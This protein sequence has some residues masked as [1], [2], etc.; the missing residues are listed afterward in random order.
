MSIRI[1]VLPGAFLIGTLPLAAQQTTNTGDSRATPPATAADAVPRRDPE[2]SHRDRPTT[3]PRTLRT[4]PVEHQPFVS[5]QS[6]AQ[7]KSDD[8]VGQ[9]VV[10]A[11]ADSG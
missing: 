3:A 6:A 5:E 1:P 10:G 11:D 8:S 2:P 4:P 7:L 9:G